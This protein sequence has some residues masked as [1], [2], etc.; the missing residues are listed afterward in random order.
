MAGFSGGRGLGG[1]N[2][3]NE[4]AFGAESPRAEGEAPARPLQTMLGAVLRNAFDFM[5]LVLLHVEAQK[6]IT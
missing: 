5:L 1:K 2:P 4:P 3:K 6:S